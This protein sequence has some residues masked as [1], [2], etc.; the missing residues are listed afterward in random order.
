[1]RLTVFIALVAGVSAST[2]SGFQPSNDDDL[3]I[4]FGSGN[5]LQDATH[6][7]NIARAGKL[8]SSPLLLQNT[9][10]PIFNSI[11]HPEHR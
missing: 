8:L 10:Y 2:P 11:L 1:M 6:G 3:L 4:T 7:R 5:S 9:T